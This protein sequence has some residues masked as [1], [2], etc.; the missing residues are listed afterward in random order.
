M[1]NINIFS[2]RP[3][4]RKDSIVLNNNAKTILGFKAKNILKDYI[5]NFIKTH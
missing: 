2:K 3:G 4:D 1:L 5:E